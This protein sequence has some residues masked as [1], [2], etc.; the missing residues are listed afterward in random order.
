MARKEWS[1]GWGCR[2][3]SGYKPCAPG[4]RCG[5]CREPEPWGRRIL[6]ISLEALGA[7]IQTTSVLAPLQRKWAPMSL[8]WVAMPENLP[9]LYNNPFIF[10][11]LP[12]DFETFEI[13]R[14]QRFDIAINLDKTRR[15]AA[16]LQAVSAEQKQGFGLSPHGQIMPVNAEAEYLYRLGLDDELKFRQNQYPGTRLIAEALGLEWRRD[17]YVLRLTENE[18]QEVRRMRQRLGL[19][20]AVIV[21]FNTGSSAHFPHKSLT[22]EQ[23]ISL[24]QLVRQ[25]CPEA[26]LALLG[27]PAEGE[28]NR[29]IAAAVKGV[30]E[31]PTA[32]GLRRGLQAVALC[33]VVVTG[34]TAALHM[35]IGL[36]C[37]A[38]AWFGL[39]CAAEIDL[40][41]WGEKLVSPLPCAPCWKKDCQDPRC[42]REMEL[43]AIAAAV[44]RGVAAVRQRQEEFSPAVSL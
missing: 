20:G 33:D 10:E 36:G 39:S 9:V 5:E 30:L 38:V 13:I 32:E 3:F 14:Q 28:R 23:H 19:E 6:L 22:V 31:T 12:Y 16:L 4:R 24:L 2:R 43:D 42:V 25:E 40:Y 21:G 26:V 34:D 8:T 7:V 29:Q 35:A 18:A 44:R 41:D 27:G 17:P 11:A 1:Q 15:G 37:Y